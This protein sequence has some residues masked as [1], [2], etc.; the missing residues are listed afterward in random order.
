[1]TVISDKSPVVK[2]CSIV[3]SF[4][5]ILSSSL[6]VVTEDISFSAGAIFSKNRN[7]NRDL[8]GAVLAARPERNRNLETEEQ[9]TPQVKYLLYLYG[10]GKQN[11]EGRGK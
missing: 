11:M 2:G 1:M 3:T 5:S 4:E 7:K 9:L 6:D 10:T 8:T